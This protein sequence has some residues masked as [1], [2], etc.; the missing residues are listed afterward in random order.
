MAD[1]ARRG[2]DSERSALT[3]A[4]YC[5]LPTPDFVFIV[6]LC[7]ERD[8]ATGLSG[9]REGNATSADGQARIVAFV[10]SPLD[11]HPVWFNTIPN[12]VRA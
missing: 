12:C 11:L 10:S 1:S 2:Q 9:R 5:S 6:F 3:I 8:M 7:P 4:L